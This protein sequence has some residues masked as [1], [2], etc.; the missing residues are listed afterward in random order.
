MGYELN[1]TIIKM[2]ETKQVSERFSKR[3]FVVETADNPK[4]PQT[5]LL[6]ATGDRM[7]QLDGFGVGD[8]VRVEFSIRGRAWQGNAET[9]YFTTLDV[10]RVESA[11]PRVTQRTD[12]GGVRNDPAP[13]ADPPNTGGGDMPEDDI[14]FASCSIAHEPSPIARVLR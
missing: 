13:P 4:Y 11:G 9:K 3:E 5:I 2:F 1:G 14:P 10:W 8:S 6:T 7:A 12:R